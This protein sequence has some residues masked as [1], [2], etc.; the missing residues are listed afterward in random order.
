MSESRRYSSLSQKYSIF[1]GLLLCYLIVIFLAYDIAK[2]DFSLIKAGILS[3]TV[4]LVAGAISKYTN[5]LLARPLSLLQAGTAAV[6]DGNLKPIQVSRTGD[7]IELLGESFNAM[8]KALVASASKEDRRLMFKENGNMVALSMT[9][10]SGKKSTLQLE[11]QDQSS[12]KEALP[13]PKEGFA[14]AYPYL[15]NLL[16]QWK[17]E[18]VRFGMSPQA[19]KETGNVKGGWVRLIEDREEDQYLSLL[20]WL[21]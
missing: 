9:S 5:R 17:S 21:V 18:L 1:T 12:D 20:V 4:L 19:D 2:D 3:V 13:L 6:R 7:E 14:L 15:L 8:I 10:T 16:G 11:L